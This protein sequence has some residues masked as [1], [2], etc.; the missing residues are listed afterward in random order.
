MA[1][2]IVAY[3]HAFR[4]SAYT[5]ALLR[6]IREQCA[7]IPIDRVLDVGVG[8]GIFLAELGHLGAQELWGVD[9]SA[10][11]LIATQQ[12]LDEEVMLLTRHLLQGNMWDPLP[13]HL[14]FDVIVANLPHFPAHVPHADRPAT[15]TGGEGRQMMDDFIEALPNRLTPSGIALITHHDLVGLEHTSHV[16]R[17]AGLT[18]ETVALWTVFETPE[19]MSAV[20]EQ[21]LASGG[22]TLR[23]LGGY[24]FMDARVIA[25]RA[26]AEVKLNMMT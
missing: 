15:W 11:A 7:D 25:I 26:G 22:E 5:T 10:D 20:S 12:L 1:S 18:F 6:V 16:I 23:Y 8:S 24:A 3:H 17:S 13:T 2:P 9:I 21:T 14:R 4:P 19:R